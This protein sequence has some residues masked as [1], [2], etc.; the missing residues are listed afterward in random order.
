MNEIPKFYQNFIMFTTDSEMI[1]KEI[2]RHFI[3]NK[4][5]L[6]TIQKLFRS[7]QKHGVKIYILDVQNIQYTWDSS[8]NVSVWT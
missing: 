1:E 3:F 2:F 7:I 4:N 8:W 6:K 5:N